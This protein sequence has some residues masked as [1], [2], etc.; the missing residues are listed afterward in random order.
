MLWVE[1][2]NYNFKVGRSF[3]AVW[4]WTWD[5]G[6]VNVDGPYDDGKLERTD[7]N[8]TRTDLSGSLADS[9]TGA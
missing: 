3:S 5:G 9:A 7:D 8:R 2:S 1:V 4:Y 6:R